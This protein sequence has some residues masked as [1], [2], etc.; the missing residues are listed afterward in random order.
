MCASFWRCG[1]R[2]CAR[3]RTGT[4]A[5]GAADESFRRRIFF[6]IGV[7]HRHMVGFGAV[8]PRGP[9]SGAFGGRAGSPR[10]GSSNRLGGLRA[11]ALPVALCQFCRGVDCAGRRG[12]CTADP[13][14]VQTQDR[15]KGRRRAATGGMC[16]GTGGSG[17]DNYWER[18]PLGRLSPRGLVGCHGLQG[19]GV[20]KLARVTGV[21]S[22]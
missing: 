16:G 1:S 12:V 8:V 2:S 13:S 22:R 17:R 3:A 21:A 19:A 14:R 7:Y 5:F 11:V 20:G 10:A 18:V 9:R 6:P 15:K 4:V